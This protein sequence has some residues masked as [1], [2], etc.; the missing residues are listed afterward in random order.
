MIVDPV[1]FLFLIPGLLLGGYAQMRLQSTYARAARIPARGGLTGAEAAAAVMRGAGV[2]G[3][4]IEP[5]AGALTDH[6][7]PG[8]KVLRLSDG[9]YDVP[10]VA[11][12]GIAAHEAGHA[13][14]D[15]TRYAPLV[16]RNLMVPL[17][18]AGGNL[19]MLLIMA[20]LALLLRPLVYLGIAAF[21]L[22][23]L[24]QLINLPVEY[25][26]SARAKRELVNQGLISPDEEPEVAR[27]LYAAALTYVA[28]TVSAVFTLLY[29][30]FRAGLIG[31]D[32]RRSDG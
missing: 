22:T 13:I 2:T 25:D 5:I 24:F 18:S 31:G 28:G 32:R 11:A 16:V 17:A 9:V 10:S 1:Y 12:V 26:A 4:R 7:S 19:S 27:V 30:L 23:V 15:A 20:G 6:Y 29:F 8:E 3:V 21:G 14:Q